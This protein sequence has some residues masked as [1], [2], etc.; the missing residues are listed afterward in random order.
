MMGRQTDAPIPEKLEFNSATM[1]TTCALVVLD[2]N[3][4]STDEMTFTSTGGNHAEEN[5]I[6]WLQEQVNSGYL[7]SNDDG[8]AD[9]QLFFQVS[10]SP[11]SS[12]TIPATRTD[13]RL[14]CSERLDNLRRYGLIRPGLNATAVRFVVL[15][16]ATKIYQPKIKGGKA[17][18]KG[19][20]DDFGD[21]NGSGSYPVVR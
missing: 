11:C 9:Y 17:A 7:T 6:N 18:A 13:G 14:G 5:A 1:N 2:R 20:Y 16:A 4:N 15:V 21:N 3:G 12:T 19:D 8:D 10:K